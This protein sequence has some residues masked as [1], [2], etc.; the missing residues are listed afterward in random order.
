MLAISED[1]FRR[2]FKFER[3]AVWKSAE[4]GMGGG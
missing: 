2:D 1:D 4:I 3:V